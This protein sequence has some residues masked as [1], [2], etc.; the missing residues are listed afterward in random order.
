MTNKVILNSDQQAIFNQVISSSGSFFVT[1]GAGTGKSV[2][3]KEIVK[4]YNQ[5]N[6]AVVAPTGIAA[7]NVDGSTIHSFFHLDPHDIHSSNLTKSD[8]DRIEVLSILII[9]EMSMV[10]CD[11]FD[12][13]NEI[14]Q[15]IKKNNLFFGGIKLLMFGDM[16]QLSPITDDGIKIVGRVQLDKLK[17][18]YGIKENNEYFFFY[19]MAFNNFKKQISFK[20]LTI[21]ERQKNDESGYLELLHKIRTGNELKNMDF[22][23][24]NQC[25]SELCPEDTTCIT[26]TRDKSLRINRERLDSIRGDSVVS[27]GVI[28]NQVIYS[29]IKD[30]LPEQSLEFKVG[31]FI[32]MTINDMDK[33][34]V[35]G[36]FGRIESIDYDEVGSP[37]A[38][39]VSIKNKNNEEELIKII[40]YTWSIRICDASNSQLKNRFVKI[41]EQFPFRLGWSI[42][43]H[44]SQGQ[45]YERI[46]VSVLDGWLQHGLY[47]VALSRCKTIRG[48]KLDTAITKS[49]IIH[50]REV[51]N[52][53]A[54]YFNYPLEKYS[55]DNKKLL[56]EYYVI[57]CIDEIGLEEYEVYCDGE[58]ICN[59]HREE[60]K[61]GKIMYFFDKEQN[62]IEI[63]YFKS[64]DLR[65]SFKDKDYV[66]RGEVK[67]E[68]PFPFNPREHEYALYDEQYLKISIFG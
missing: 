21:N 64:Q 51:D 25:V 12:K 5:K 23:I 9:D 68:K 8:I 38:V 30:N 7:I 11:L 67:V 49:N 58:F 37:V 41:Y 1:G 48:L 56:A 46:Y 36:T 52:F 66:C 45:T 34:F 17:T 31:A 20:E 33:R 39:F 6:I 26:A 65:V 55:L 22:E 61:G 53:M 18:D 63:N 35:N 42:T 10:R 15:K 44:K 54:T 19:S 27:R 60:Y 3:L 62:Q 50:S 29:D 47:Y 43:I 2:L 14:C 40:K 57:G 13:M 24:L 32:I 16:Y 4:F 28:F 59:A